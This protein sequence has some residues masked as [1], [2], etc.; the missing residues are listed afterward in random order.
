MQTMGGNILKEN[1]KYY[2]NIRL[3]SQ[4]LMLLFQSLIYT[5][6][7]VLNALYTGGV[8]NSHSLRQAWALT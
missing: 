2:T 8:V 5:L 4:I 3:Y 7:C 1:K 6:F